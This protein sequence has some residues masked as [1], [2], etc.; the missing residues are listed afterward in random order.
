MILTTL[1]S[2]E[3]TPSPC[4]LCPWEHS[5]PFSALLERAV[6]VLNFSAR[7]HFLF[8]CIQSS[9]PGLCGVDYLLLS[10]W[11]KIFPVLCATRSAC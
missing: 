3:V 4:S 6:P 11:Q 7:Q 5:P 1:L 9:K 2:T 8:C 10:I